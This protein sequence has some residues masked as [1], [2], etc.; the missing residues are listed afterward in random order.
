MGAGRHRRTPGAGNL[1]LLNIFINIKWLL[2]WENERNFSPGLFVY[3]NRV[4]RHSR[5][6]LPSSRGHFVRR[7]VSLMDCERGAL[8]WID[9]QYASFVFFITPFPS[10]TKKAEEFNKIRHTLLQLFI[11]S[12]RLVQSSASENPP[13]L[14]CIVHTHSFGL[15]CTGS[16]WRKDTVMCVCVCGVCAALLLFTRVRSEVEWIMETR[17]WCKCRLLHVHVQF[18]SYSSYVIRSREMLYVSDRPFHMK[19]TLSNLFVQ[20]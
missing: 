3:I 8:I 11:I 16:T 20:H 6:Q 9:Y 19:H 12:P 10:F 17:Y 5:E 13:L 4:I 14:A 2:F 18:S 7:A 1:F 15:D